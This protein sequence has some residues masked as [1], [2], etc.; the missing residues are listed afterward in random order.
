M[1]R[2][3][4]LDESVDAR[5]GAR[6]KAL[7]RQRDWSLEDLAGHSGVS[8]ASLSR[9]EKGEVSATAAVM[10]RL[11]ETYGITM[12][13]LIA[14]AETDFEPLVARR[15]QPVWQDPDSGLRRRTLSPPS[16]RLAAE[17]V[18]CELPA[19]CSL[20]YGVPARPGAE[21]HLCLLEGALSLT[22]ESESY[23]LTPGDCLRYQLFGASHFQTEAARGA[24]YILVTL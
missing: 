9:L 4:R 5:I 3:R 10:W 21:H 22:F 23:H 19:G 12:S 20:A 1:S 2:D 14:G 11:C 18:E 15:D 13:R 6:L 7:R 17:V 8:R 16:A 24:R